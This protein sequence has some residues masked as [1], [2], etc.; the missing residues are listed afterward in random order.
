MAN[1]E[2]VEPGFDTLKICVLL[3]TYNNAG[4]LAPLLQDIG[5]FTKNILI[6][7][8]GSTDQTAEILNGF[9]E[10][11]QVSYAAN[12]GK[13]FALRQGFKKAL[14][15]G[16]DYVI[17]IDSDG[18]HFASDLPAFLQALEISP[19]TLFIGARN[20][21]QPEVPGK[22]S[23]G[24]RFS[25]FWFKVE[26]GIALPDTQSGYRLYPVYRLKDMH[27][28]TRKYEFEIEVIVRAAWKGIPVKPVP[29][30]VYYPPP[31]ERISHFRPFRDFT[32]ISILN[33]FL[34]LIAFLYIKP[35]DFFRKFTRQKKWREALLHELLHPHQ[36]D[37]RKS[38]SAG[39]GIFMGIIPIWG[40]QLIVAIFLSVIL[41]LNKVLV[42]LF[43]NIS[44]PPMIP[45]IIYA[46]YR[47]GAWW[48]PK[49][50]RDIS[51]SKSLSLSAIRYNFSQYNFSQ[52]L[53]GSITL[54]VISGMAA[55][56]ITFGLLKI[57]KKKPGG[58]SW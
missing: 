50:A 48:M 36:S 10:I 4:T 35:R 25:N 26:T 18:Q 34:V 27:F 58:P 23:F 42:V 1:Y 31:G 30:S 52:Y 49:T 13:G 39:F 3:A 6:V 20:M 17:T 11:K 7:N 53:L 33:T 56:I 38:V 32:R 5:A 37:T 51:F 22:S 45:F 40:F 15:L 12:R 14:A 55:G 46:S 47:A 19:G 2:N 54:A 24:N 29:V 44:V 57:F 16:Y 28:F 9:P 43:A 21:D 8:D 41:K